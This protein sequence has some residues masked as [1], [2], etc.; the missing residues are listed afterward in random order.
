MRDASRNTQRFNFVCSYFT[1]LRDGCE[2][3]FKA[4]STRENRRYH[5]QVDPFAKCAQAPITAWYFVSIC[6]EKTASTRT[7]SFSIMETSAFSCQ[8][9]MAYQPRFW[10]VTGDK[11]SA[12]TMADADG[13][14]EEQLLVG[15]DDFE[16][17]VRRTER[18]ATA[19]RYRAQ[20]CLLYTSPS[21]RDATLSRMPSSA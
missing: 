16:V 20:Y 17:G 5:Q 13:G 15:S 10:T 3:F 8:H 21:P 9:A 19:V 2:G 11:V 14:G 12:M 7:R 1:Q 6:K 18:P 4:E